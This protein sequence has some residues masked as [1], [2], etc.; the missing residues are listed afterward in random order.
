MLLSRFYKN[1]TELPASYRILPKII[2]F[3]VPGFEKTCAGSQ[4]LSITY[5]SCKTWF[6]D[7]YDRIEGAIGRSFLPVVRLCDGEYIFITGRSRGSLRHWFWYRWFLNMRD[8]QRRLSKKDY[9]AGGGRLYASG[10]YS[11]A[12]RAAI[13]PEY[14]KQLRWIADRGILAIQFAWSIKPF[15][16][17]AWPDL[18]KAFDA[19]PIRL[20]ATNYYPFYFVYALVAGPEAKRVFQNRRILVVNSTAGEKREAITKGL[21]KRGAASIDWLSISTDRSFYDRIDVSPYVGRMDLALVGAGIGKPN[22]FRQLEPL[23][24]PC[25]DIGYYF[26]VL[27]NEEAKFWRP[28]CCL[29]AEL[30]IDKVGFLDGNQKR[31]LLSQRSNVHLRKG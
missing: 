17:S 19:H 13:L 7:F 30:D 26:E 11:S 25:L 18:K 6:R 23:Q 3:K 16:E 29:D 1:T 8:I 9:I 27:A 31:W 5:D 20:T 4:T 24:V 22:I 15:D 12:E 14:L 2:E 28:M 21:R 10:H